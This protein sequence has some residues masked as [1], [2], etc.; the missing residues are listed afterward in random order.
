MLVGAQAD[1]INWD[2]GKRAQNKALVVSPGAVMP[3]AF[4]GVR[5]VELDACSMHLQ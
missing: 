1:I 3:A 4:L 2:D 5:D